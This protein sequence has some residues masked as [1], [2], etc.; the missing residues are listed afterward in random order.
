MNSAEIAEHQAEVDV[1]IFEEFSEWSR[2]GCFKLRERKG[3]DNIIDST[4]VAKWKKD[5]GKT[6][7]YLRQLSSIEDPRIITMHDDAE[8]SQG[9]A[10]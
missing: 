8:S 7:I 6:Y 10:E 9:L 3:A 5:G 1:A 4:L 2:L